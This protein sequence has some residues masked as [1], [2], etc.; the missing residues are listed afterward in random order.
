MD[1][2]RKE[3]RKKVMAFTPVYR[4]E[5]GKTETLLGFLGDLTLQGALVIG[6]KTMEEGQAVTLGIEFPAS[7]P[8]IAETRLTIGAKVARCVHEEGSL[9]FRLGFEFVIPDF[10]QAA[11]IEALIERYHYRHSQ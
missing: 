2:R 3:P 8:G 7:L 11:I 6:Q 9:D 1:N 5:P 10:E 4:L